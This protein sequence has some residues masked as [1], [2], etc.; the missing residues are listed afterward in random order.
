MPQVGKA[1]R[2][3]TKDKVKKKATKVK[4]KKKATKNHE[5]RLQANTKM[6]LVTVP[7][8]AQGMI[9][10]TTKNLCLDKKKELAQIERIRKWSD[11][12][13]SGIDMGVNSVEGSCQLIRTVDQEV[14]KSLPQ[15]KPKTVG[16]FAIVWL[17]VGYLADEAK[18]LSSEE[19]RRDWNFLTS[20][21][22]TWIAM[23]LDQAPDDGT[24]YEEVAGDLADRAWKIIFGKPREYFGKL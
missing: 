9:H 17:M 1:K 24:D 10:E 2:K 4:V 6:A 16:H 11:K 14:Q 21:I 22:N 5:R 8:I 18:M 7:A 20:T 15:D 3:I 23:M 19:R 12:C 13:L